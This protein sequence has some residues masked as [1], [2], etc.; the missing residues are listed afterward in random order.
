MILYF[1][2]M[3]Y[4]AQ[5][6]QEILPEI[7]KKGKITNNLIKDVSRRNKRLGL[8]LKQTAKNRIFYTSELKEVV[9]LIQ[10]DPELSKKYSKNRYVSPFNAQ[11][12]IEQG[13]RGLKQKKQEKILEND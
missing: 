2:S 6:L 10:S 1:L 12:K 9:E 8:L 5:F 13:M 4:P 7:L 3:A 11:K